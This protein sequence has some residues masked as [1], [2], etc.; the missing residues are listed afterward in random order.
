MTKKFVKKNIQLNLEL[1][2]YLT[3]HPKLYD[4]IPNGATLVITLKSDKKF[5][6]DSISIAMS[7]KPKQPIIR[8][9]KVRSGWTL[10]PLTLVAV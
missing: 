10:S 8:A 9:E 3:K 6:E 5:T 7:H 4:T 1:D 2:D